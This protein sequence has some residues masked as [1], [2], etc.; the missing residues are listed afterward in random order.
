LNKLILSEFEI[1]AKPD[2]A[3][4]ERAGYKRVSLGIVVIKAERSGRITARCALTRAEMYDAGDINSGYKGTNEL[5]KNGQA[6]LLIVLRIYL[7]S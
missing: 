2:S 4:S 7:M 6:N 1:S 3:F 5:I